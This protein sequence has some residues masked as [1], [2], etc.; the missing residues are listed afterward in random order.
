MTDRELLEAAAKAAGYAVIGWD[1]ALPDTPIIV[2]DRFGC[3]ATLK[4]VW[5]PLTDD[6]DAFRLAVALKI[7]IRPS[8]AGPTRFR[9]TTVGASTFA[10]QGT[11]AC[12][13]TRRA[14]VRAAAEIG[15]NMP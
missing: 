8:L 13:A 9:Y 15:K 12:D 11:N 5:M 2:G 3:G 1:N 4:W 6:G 14:I 10:A 7:D